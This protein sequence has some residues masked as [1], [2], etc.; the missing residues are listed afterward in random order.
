MGQKHSENCFSILDTASTSFQLK[1]K[2]AF[3]THRMG[4]LLI[5]LRCYLVFIYS[6]LLSFISHRLMVH[7]YSQLMGVDHPKHVLQTKNSASLPQ[8]YFM[9]ATVVRKTFNTYFTTL[10]FYSNFLCLPEFICF[11]IF[12]FILTLT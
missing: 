11:M 5:N 3:N 1:I 4:K 7:L 10:V 6:I 12:F 8:S 9:S 2:E